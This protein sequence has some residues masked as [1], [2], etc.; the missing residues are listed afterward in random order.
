MEWMDEL[1]IKARQIVRTVKSD[2][3]FIIIDK[4]HG[5]DD[6]SIA[7]V[8]NLEDE[9]DGCSLRGTW[10]DIIEDVAENYEFIGKKTRQDLDRA[11]KELRFAK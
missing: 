6:Y 7:W 8:D 9:N 11:L 10:D 1:G 5:Y 2:V 3:K 4:Y